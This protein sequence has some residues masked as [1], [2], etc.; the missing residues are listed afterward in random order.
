[1]TSSSRT[2]AVTGSASGIGAAF[3]SIVEAEGHR[4][5]SVD[6]MKADVVADLSTV[7]GRDAAVAGVLDASNGTLDGFVGFAGVSE[8]LESLVVSVNYFGSIAVLDG[9]LPALAKGDRPAAVAVSSNSVAVG[10]PDE[11]LVGAM[12]DGDEA[13]A[14]AL[15]SGR[16]AYPESK[17]ALA[18]AVRR[19]A[20]TWADAGV[21]LNAIA[22][23]PTMTPMLQLTLDH[24][25]HGPMLREHYPIPLG[26]FGEPAE[27]AEVVRWMLGD[28]ASYLH[29]AVLFLDGGSDA[30]FRP[31][32]V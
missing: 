10:R 3:C 27:V 6:R 29:G 21:R 31:D 20:Q 26:R 23:G 32:H 19:R 2:Y 25:E 22:P 7:A 4:V 24:P 12:L 17:R 14:T 18:R 15:A 28:T 5:I 13:R 16:A 1:M 11:E 8:A 9:L 30:A